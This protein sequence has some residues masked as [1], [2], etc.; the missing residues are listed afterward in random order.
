MACREHQLVLA[1]EG[2]KTPR[3]LRVPDACVLRLLAV[4]GFPDALETR[5]RQ[6]E[7]SGGEPVLLDAAPPG[8]HADPHGDFRVR[9]RVENDIGHQAAAADARFGS[10]GIETGQRQVRADDFPPG[11]HAILRDAGSRGRMQLQIIDREKNARRR[12]PLPRQ[13]GVEG[14]GLRSRERFRAG[15]ATPVRRHPVPQSFG[16]GGTVYF[17]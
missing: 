16:D 4:P 13:R 15:F 11:Y 6:V 14:T 7:Q 2:R 17:Q 1:P 5:R 12:T 3:D 8:F 9:L 10:E